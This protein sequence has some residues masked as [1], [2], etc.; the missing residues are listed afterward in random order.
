[1]IIAA[2]W[3]M[4]LTWDEAQNLVQAVAKKSSD[5]HQDEGDL[6]PDIV[7]FPPALYA[8]LVHDATISLSHLSWGGQ[9]THIQDSGAHTGDISAKMFASAGATFQLIGHSERRCD[10]NETDSDIAAQLIASQKAGLDV[11]LCVGESLDQREEGNEISVVTSQIA[12]ATEGLANLDNIIIAYEPIW[13][14]GTGRVAE[15]E[16]VFAMHQ[17]IAQFCSTEL[18]VSQRPQILYGGSVKAANAASLFALEYVDGALVG[19]ASL[20]CAE[21]MGIVDA[22]SRQMRLS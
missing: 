9:T 15:A 12:K 5:R 18:G 4:N 14:I 7:I 8:S 22:A 6:Y 17:A 16:D 10:H 3:K 1:M 13:A 11:I 2:N 19:G 21:F 20:D